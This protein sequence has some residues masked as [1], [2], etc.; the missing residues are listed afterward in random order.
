MQ[1]TYDIAYTIARDMF[2]LPK[3]LAKSTNVLDKFS[4]FIL[5]LFDINDLTSGHSLKTELKATVNIISTFSFVNPEGNLWNI[6][7]KK[8]SWSTI[9]KI[10]T[11]GSKILLF[12]AQGIDFFK[13]LDQLEILPFDIVESTLKKVPLFSRLINVSP[14]LLVL[15]NSMVFVSTTFV[16]PEKVYYSF[17]VANLSRENRVTLRIGLIADLF[18]L[19]MVG[20]IV[21]IA[22]SGASLSK[23]V[24]TTTTFGAIKLGMIIDIVGIS[25]AIFALIK[26]LNKFALEQR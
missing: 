13:G 26:D 8:K 2:Y 22:L 7:F 15:K 6:N 4:K 12:G 25:S 24:C 9:N 10:L 18:K 23:V 19:V 14:T 3:G 20:A 21:G 16:L 1:A 11:V 17:F 5:Q